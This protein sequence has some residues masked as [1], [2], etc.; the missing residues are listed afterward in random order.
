MHLHGR[1]AP[2]PS[3]QNVT[4]RLELH[5]RAPHAAVAGEIEVFTYEPADEP[6]WVRGLRSSS[7]EVS[8]AQVEETID[9][10]IAGLGIAR[11]Y[12]FLVQGSCPADG[13]SVATLQPV[14]SADEQSL[15]SHGITVILRCAPAVRAIPG[16]IS[17]GSG[18]DDGAAERRLAIVSDD[19]TPFAI[20]SIQAPAGFHVRGVSDDISEPRAAH[21]LQ[22]EFYA[23]GLAQD[24]SYITIATT[25]AE[26]R[27]IKV[28][29]RI[30]DPPGAN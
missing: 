4:R 5:G 22:L 1:A 18:A 17:L 24:P 16:E 21:V 30:A 23:P 26:C 19:E 20:E 12:R 6:A 15:A 28:P 7:P 9:V 29:I 25:H 2:V 10:P 3:I 14:V 27:E 8:A 13:Q 11:T